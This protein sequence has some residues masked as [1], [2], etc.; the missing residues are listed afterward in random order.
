MDTISFTLVPAAELPSEKLAFLINQA[1]ADYMI[2]VWIEQE[3]FVRQC[4]EEDIDLN[5]SVVALASSEPIGLA[6]LSKRDNRG[7][8]SGVGVLPQWRRRGIARQMMRHLQ[9]TAQTLGLQTLTL[10]VL[11][12]NRVALNLYHELGFNHRRELT[13]IMLEAGSTA[14]APLPEPIKVTLPAVLVEHY[15]L[16]HDVALPWQ[17]EL[18]T[19]NHRLPFMAGL[20]LWDN[21]QLIG[22]LLYQTQRRYQLIYDLALSPA[23]PARLE[24]ARLLLRA[25]H[26]L[27]PDLGGYLINLPTDDPL[28]PVFTQLGYRT[29]QRQYEMTW[30][31]QPPAA[32]PRES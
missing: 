29:W 15:A 13:V 5:I 7:W 12:Q 17:R 1:Y 27:R 8:I 22:Y 26:Q 25:L 28:F 19:L 14:Y 30:E 20:G 2:P 31:C 6:L 10:E 3:Q 21:H 32:A 11:T 24:A 16:F 23:Y 18:P 9:A 4:I